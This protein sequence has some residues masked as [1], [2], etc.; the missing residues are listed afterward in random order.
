MAHY[1]L[2]GRI[3]AITGSTGG[4]GNALATELR[5]RG[6]NLALM[7]ING[8]A[9]VT[10]AASLGGSAVARAYRV[11]VRDLPTLEA[12]MDAAAAEFGRLDVVIAGAGVE[13]M[14]PM[15]LMRPDEFERT[16]DIHLTGVWRTFR[17]ALPHVQSTQGY[18]LAISSMAAFVHS[19]LQAPYAASKA[20]IWAMSDSIRLEL[21]HVGVD[22][23]TVHPTF[24]RTPM[25]DR[26]LA[27]PAGRRLWGE[28]KSPL[29]RMVPLE[30][31]VAETVAAIERRA[32]M[33]V[34]PKRVGPVARAA[35]LARPLI[36]RIGWPGSTI[37]QTIGLVGAPAGKVA[38][39]ASQQRER[40]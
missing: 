8:D 14:S 34:I 38:R 39:H 31:V 20:A 27:N 15:A 11:D 12:A 2:A 33:T 3:V 5:K 32:A 35:G 17:A 7:D 29:W 19:P 26:V 21:R 30:L 25:M 1:E 4:L 37:E 16:I 23:G 18:L 40:V 9:L 13:V 22:V 10:Q 6:A 28:H 24:F 36:D